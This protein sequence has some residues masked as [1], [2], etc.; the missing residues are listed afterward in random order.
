MSQAAFLQATPRGWANN[1]THMDRSG[2]H[3][4]LDKP[5]EELGISAELYGVL[6]ASRIGSIREATEV[7]AHQLLQLPG[8]GY[9]MMHEF[10]S[11]LEKHQSAHL[12]QE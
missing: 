12:L 2:Q 4:F 5:L 7:E 1:Q 6:K 3:A 10:V 9:R 8:F 11:L